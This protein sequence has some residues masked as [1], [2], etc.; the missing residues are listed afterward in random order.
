[1]LH[2]SFILLLGPEGWPRHVLL[3]VEIEAQD[4]EWQLQGFSSP[5]LGIIM[6]L[7]LL[8]SIDHSKSQGHLQGRNDLPP[9]TVGEQGKREGEVVGGLDE[10]GDM[11]RRKADKFQNQLGAGSI[12]ML[13]KDWL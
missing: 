8:H 4:S 10:D 2:M 12:G 6:W 13:P 7:L 3:I 5:A 9:A 11:R 1:M